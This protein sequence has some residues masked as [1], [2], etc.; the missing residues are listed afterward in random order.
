MVRQLN[1]LPGSHMPIILYGKMGFTDP[2]YKLEYFSCQSRLNQ[3]ADYNGFMP[4]IM[5]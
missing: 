4:P 2:D 5:C 1:F 3:L